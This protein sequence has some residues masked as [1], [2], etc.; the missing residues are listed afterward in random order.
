MAVTE[1]N[2]TLGPPE[3]RWRV[4]AAMAKERARCSCTGAIPN[5]CFA[6]RS[7]LQLPLFSHQRRVEARV[8]VHLELAVDLEVGAA[9][10]GRCRRFCPQLHGRSPLAHHCHRLSQTL[11]EQSVQI[12]VCRLGW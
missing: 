7:P 12:F 1:G 9:R 10:L 8:V 6:G 11:R 3:E 5:G 2:H 4:P